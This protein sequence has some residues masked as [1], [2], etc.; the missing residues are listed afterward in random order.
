MVWGMARVLGSGGREAGEGNV[1]LEVDGVMQ[2]GED[3]GG[4]WKVGGD[5]P[6]TRLRR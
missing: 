2:V 3:A 6:E 1:V 5:L 4:E